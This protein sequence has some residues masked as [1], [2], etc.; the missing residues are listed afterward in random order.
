MRR[1]WLPMPARRELRL[2]GSAEGPATTWSW[3]ERTSAPS[4]GGAGHDTLVLCHGVAFGG[5]GNDVISVGEWD[6]SG[7][8][9]FGDGNLPTFADEDIAGPTYVY[10]GPGQDHVD[11]AFRGGED[12]ITVTWRDYTPGDTLSLAFYAE[13]GTL[14]ADDATTRDWLDTDDNHVLN[15]ADGNIFGYDV[16]HDP[17]FNTLSL[18]IDNDV[19]ELSNTDFLLI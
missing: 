16:S 11:M 17:R 9:A 14:I 7:W 18:R 19:I 2:A 13:D 12:P 6:D 3:A 8:V 1:R 4:K 5:T 10:G 15:D